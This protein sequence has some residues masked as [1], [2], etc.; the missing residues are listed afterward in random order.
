[1][2][3]L[4][5]GGALAAGSIASNI[6]SANQAAAAAD[7]AMEA[8]GKAASSIRGAWDSTKGT[9]KDNASAIQA[10]KDIVDQTYGD[11]ADM[12]KKYRE[13]LS[14]DMSDNIYKPSNYSYDKNIDQFYDKAWKLNNQTQLDAL[15]A[16]ASNAG[17]LYSS[18]L[19]N[20]M[21]NTASANANN[22]YKEAMKAY[23]EDKNMDITRWSTEEKNKQAAAQQYLDNYKTRLNAYGDY[24]GNS[25]GAYGDI[26]SA[27]INNNNSK[28]N[29]YANYVGNYANLLAQAGDYANNEVLN[30]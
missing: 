7:D 11:R 16:S 27:T 25:L 1:M 12:T 10:Y 2:V 6:Y 29:T 20:Q 15:E 5:V 9:Y 8:A 21:A 30:Y 22:A 24:V 26:A 17:N 23:L 18:G 13:L 4:I 28:A 19:L 3:P 14:Q